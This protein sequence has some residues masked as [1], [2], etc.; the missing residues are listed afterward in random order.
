[1]DLSHHQA[2]FIRSNQI[3]LLLFQVTK[4]TRAMNVKKRKRV[5]VSVKKQNKTKQEIQKIH[6]GYKV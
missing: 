2:R 4:G 1:M 3:L 5:N 6:V